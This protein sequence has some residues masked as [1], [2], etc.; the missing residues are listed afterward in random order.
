[1]VLVKGSPS[2][3]DYFRATKTISLVD[4]FKLLSRFIDYFLATKPCSPKL[5]T[6][7]KG[8]AI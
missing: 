3:D 7:S 4:S 8:Q 6:Y 2:R 1:M 5:R